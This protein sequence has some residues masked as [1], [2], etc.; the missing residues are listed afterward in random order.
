MLLD[1]AEIYHQYSGMVY[2]VALRMTGRVEE[3]EEVT[4]DVFLSVH[5]HLGAFSGKSTI[6]TWV[7][8]IAVNCS[9]NAIKKAGRKRPEVRMEE[10]FDAPDSR[11]DV[12]EAVEKEAAEEKIQALLNEVSEDERACLLLR[13][14]EGLSYEDIARSLGVNINTV[15]TRIRRARETMIAAYQNKR[16]KI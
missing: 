1:F 14:Q 8:R 6:K 13:A 3:A 10:G 9:L 12:H 2:R 11:Q 4:Q 5:R 16:G 15:K 7:Y